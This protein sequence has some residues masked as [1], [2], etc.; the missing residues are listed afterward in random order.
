M[1]LSLSG[2][3]IASSMKIGKLI[4]YLRRVEHRNISNAPEDL[5]RCNDSHLWLSQVCDGF[6]VLSP[7]N[8]TKLGKLLSVIMHKME[9]VLFSS[10]R[11]CKLIIG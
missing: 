11:D 5:R 8:G 6:L 10:Q 9:T 3:P 7:Y 1:S 2:Q 4:L